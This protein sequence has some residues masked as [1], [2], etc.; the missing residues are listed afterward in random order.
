M[1]KQIRIQLTDE[2]EER[3]QREATTCGTTIAALVHARATSSATLPETV[4]EEA[5]DYERRKQIKIDIPIQLHEILK[6]DA[7]YYGYSLSRYISYL[8]AQKGR[9]VLVEYNYL[10]SIEEVAKIEG[11][12]KDFRN[13]VKM[14]EKQG[15][16]YSSN[17]NTIRLEAE[18]AVG[19]LRECIRKLDRKSMAYMFQIQKELNHEIEQAKK[20]AKT[21]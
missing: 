9:P 13:L 21:E 15:I 18:D 5:L 20:A 2:E 19:T 10:Q 8:L 3:L 12:C 17:I 4:R 11:F 6:V 7:E 14:A 1:A 16:L